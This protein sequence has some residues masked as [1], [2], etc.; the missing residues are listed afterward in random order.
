[1]IS[2][3]YPNDPWLKATEAE[4]Y[5]GM[6]L[7][8]TAG[9]S[10]GGVGLV[11]RDAIED[12]DSLKQ[13]IDFFN[14]QLAGAI[15]ACVEV[16]LLRSENDRLQAGLVE[17][18]V[19]SVKEHTPSN[20]YSEAYSKVTSRVHQH[21]GS[22]FLQEFVHAVCD[23]YGLF[24]G[25]ICALDPSFMDQTLN[26]VSFCVE[27]EECDT[28]QYQAKG[29]PCEHVLKNGSLYLV[30]GAAAKYPADDYLEQYKIR[31]FCGNRL[32]GPSGETAGVIWVVHKETLLYAEEI[33]S[34]F[35][36]Y[37][38]RIGAELESFMQL[39]LLMQ[40]RERL[41][42]QVA[43]QTELLAKKKTRTRV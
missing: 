7:K 38:P 23:E 20:G 9:E 40:E 17:T 16:E 10:V 15:Q 39:D 4:G 33:Q 14:P 41:E 27:N 31:G 5:L 1:G 26:S 24:A 28:I 18:G 22:A 35:K 6:S 19:K 12:L 32:P 34:L 3:Y 37:A 2:D 21:A 13:V 8:N 43:Q 42:A 30:D 36:H 25:G 29:A 11:S